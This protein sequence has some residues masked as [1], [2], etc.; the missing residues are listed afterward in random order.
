MENGM[1]SVIIPVY[2]SEEF[3]SVCIESLLEQ[4]YHHFELLLVDDGSNDRSGYICD[5]YKK[6]DAR[7]RV[8]HKKNEGVSSARNVG[9]RHCQGEYVTFVDS[10]DYVKK[11]YLEQLYHN[12]YNYHVDISVCNSAFFYENKKLKESCRLESGVIQ[13]DNQLNY[14]R[15]SFLYN[16]WG[17][18]FV[19]D[20]LKDIYFDTDLYMG[21]DSFFTAQIIKRSK[22]MYYDSKALYIYRNN[23]SSLTHTKDIE[24]W[25]TVLTAWNRIADLYESDSISYWSIKLNY[26]KHCRQLVNRDNNK[27]S[28]YQKAFK[29]NQKAIWKVKDSLSEKLLL[30][31]LAFFPNIYVT[32]YQWLKNAEYRRNENLKR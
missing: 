9:L 1:I 23:Q 19:K 20:L 10:D 21:E 25:N 18:L 24:K 6:K 8:F 30:L 4:T 14:C 29:K 5:E 22:K 11:Y 26:L 3:L 2:N 13:C 31:F 27:I 16:T 32:F 15:Y 28:I 7:I 12:L 17:K